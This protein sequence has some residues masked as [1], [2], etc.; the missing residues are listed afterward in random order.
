MSNGWAHTGFPWNHWGTGQPDDEAGSSCVASVKAL[1]FW[2]YDTANNV[3]RVNDTSNAINNVSVVSTQWPN[4]VTAASACMPC[5]IALP[6]CTL[7]HTHILMPLHYAASGV[8]LG[9]YLV[10]RPAGL[11]LRLV[12]WVTVTAAESSGCSDHMDA[13]WAAAWQ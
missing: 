12:L 3:T 7:P 5:H 10:H 9:R 6:P 2:Q 4:H 13:L 1:R 8:G 11:H